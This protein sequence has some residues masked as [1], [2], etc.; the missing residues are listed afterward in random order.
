MIFDKYIHY[1]TQIQTNQTNK[2]MVNMHYINMLK[3][4]GYYIIMANLIKLAKKSKN[5]NLSSL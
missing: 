2:N 4:Y 1:N 5:A 3:K